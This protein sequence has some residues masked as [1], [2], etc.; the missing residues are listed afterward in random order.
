M[1]EESFQMPFLIRYP[2]EI[3]AG[4]ICDDVISNVDFAALFLDYAGLRKPSYM[5][6]SSFRPLLQGQTPA[7]WKQVAYHRYWMHRDEIHEAYAHY[8]IRDQRYKLI[9]WY[10]EDFGLPG[11]RPGGQ[12]REWELFDCEKDPLEL[13][14]CY[15]EPEYREIVEKMTVMLEDTMADIGD[16]P[17]HSVLD[18]NA[19]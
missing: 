12:G 19:K 7:H 15:H 2:R 14:N 16:E 6:G 1:Y 13:F 10:N 9:Y 3:K 11:T 8:G 17:V 4:S 5:Q 18:V